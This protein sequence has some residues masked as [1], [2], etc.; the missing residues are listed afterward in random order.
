VPE[1]TPGAAVTADPAVAAPAGARIGAYDRRRFLRLFTAVM[2][3]MF[4]AAVDQTLLA[5]AT[6]VISEELGG[7]RDTSWLASAYL[8]AS[9][10]M[11]PLYGQ[12]G[13]RYGRRRVLTVA[14]AVFTLGSLACGLAPTLALLVA[15]R[16]LQGLGG[17]GL[18][19]L[20]QALIGEVVPPR[21][22]ARNQGYFAIIFTL[23]SV[24]GPVLGGLIVHYASWR[25]LFFVNLP[26]CV[27]AAWRLRGLWADDRPHRAPG[28]PDA[29]GLLLFAGA[30]GTSLY[31]LSSGGHRFGWVSVTSGV[32]LAAVLVL[33]PA[34]L[35]VERRAE[36]PFLPIDLMRRPAIRYAVLTVI[37]FASAMFA[38][39]FYLPVYLQFALGANP[40]QSGLMLLPLTAGIVCG[41]A[42]TGR[43]IV[44]TGRPTDIPKFGLLL[45][46]AS[47]GALALAPAD[48]HLLLGLGFCTGLGL[49][50]VMSVMQI[51][52]QTEAGQTRLGAAA[53][54][55][56]LARTLGSSLGASAFGALIYGSIGGTLDVAALHDPHMLG[57]VQAAFRIAFVGAAAL[58][59]CAAWTASRLPR[60]RFDEESS[61]RAG[62]V[63]E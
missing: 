53:G 29:I 28:R 17:G 3:P 45:A 60:L 19:T 32:L 52:T 7:L 33:W 4:L 47:L 42:F 36:R 27:F 26:L 31:W 2:L 22:R 41:A 1:A 59:L 15:A 37:G 58:C 46:A 9:V 21:H 38:M 43:L 44:W 34:L 6:P 49:G 30:I 18:M 56:S 25:W 16:V 51:V 11:V 63:G 5:T 12:L 13:D 55:I 8:L 20:S 54:T 39:V 14:I 10:V 48:R 24:G 62:A 57:R 35:R 23:A 61:S 50:S 40:A